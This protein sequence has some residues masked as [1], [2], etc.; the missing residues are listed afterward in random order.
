MKRSKTDRFSRKLSVI[1]ESGLQ[2]N[3]LCVSQFVFVRSVSYVLN[4][5]QALFHH[6]VSELLG[7]KVDHDVGVE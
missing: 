2:A 5:F 1:Y 4:E 3:T 7:S 6:V